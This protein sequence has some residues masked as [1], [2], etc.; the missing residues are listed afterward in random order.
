MP[1]FFSPMIE[2]HIQL[3]RTD[4]AGAETTAATR[5]RLKGSFPPGATRRMTTLGLLVGSTLQPLEPGESDTLV[6]ASAYAESCA[7]E[8]FLDSFPTPSP[9][10]F[11]T[12]IHP[13]AVQQLM[14]GRQKPVREF[15]PLSGSSLLAYHALRASLLSPSPRSLLCGGEE[16]GTWLLEH[17]LASDRTFAFAAALTTDGRGSA[18]GTVTLEAKGGEG[19]LGLPALFDLLHARTAFSGMV[20]PGWS[21]TL[22]WR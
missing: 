2:R 6:Y 19:A 4:D 21:L 16:K 3:L 12:S 10:L 7:L 14:I 17:G 8:S 9:T 20:A 13:S 11:Q 1:R 18:L 22:E 5:D 15:L